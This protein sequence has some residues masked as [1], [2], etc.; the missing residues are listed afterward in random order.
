MHC[1]VSPKIFH[2]ALVGDLLPVHPKPIENISPTPS[3]PAPSSPSALEH[4]RSGDVPQLFYLHPGNVA[5]PLPL[6]L[7]CLSPQICNTSHRTKHCIA[8]LINTFNT[9]NA[10]L[11]SDWSWV[12]TS[13]TMSADLRTVACLRLVESILCRWVGA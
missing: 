9:Q 1:W 7:G 2:C 10:A 8:Y 11:F 4:P 13:G 12:W 6:E 3:R 5:R